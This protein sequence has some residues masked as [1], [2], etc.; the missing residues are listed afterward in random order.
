MKKGL[1]IVVHASKS[2][3]QEAEA[4]SWVWGQA[5]L[6]SETCLEIKK[7]WITDIYMNEQNSKAV[8][9]KKIKMEHIIKFHVYDIPEKAKS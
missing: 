8:E 4:V 5:G 6:C 9:W 2:T 3:T 7:E 1:E